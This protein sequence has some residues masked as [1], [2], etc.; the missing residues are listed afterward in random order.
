MIP[1]LVVSHRRRPIRRPVFN[2]DTGELKDTSALADGVQ[3]KF[4][5]V[6]TRSARRAF[7]HPIPPTG[8]AT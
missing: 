7:Y 3:I 2:V 4:H 6:A 5:I 1:I 8:A